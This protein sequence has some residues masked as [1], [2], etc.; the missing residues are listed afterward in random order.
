MKRRDL[1]KLTSLAFGGAHAFDLDNDAITDER[2]RVHVQQNA[3]NG[4]VVP[5]SPIRCRYPSTLIITTTRWLL[6][7]IHPIKHVHL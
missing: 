1:F 4:A 3:V 2:I 5:K 6:K 7:L